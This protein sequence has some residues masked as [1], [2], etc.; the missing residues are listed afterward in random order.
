VKEK[1]ERIV[2]RQGVKGANVSR[3]DTKT[4]RGKQ[5]CLEKDRGGSKRLQ[6]RN[7]LVTYVLMSSLMGV[8]SL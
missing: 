1:K 2:T 8:G 4:E 3:T 6:K 5:Y 7:S